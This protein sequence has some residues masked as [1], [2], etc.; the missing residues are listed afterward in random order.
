MVVDCLRC[1]DTI[2]SFGMLLQSEWLSSSYVMWLHLSQ[3]IPC[4]VHRDTQTDTGVYLFPA[5]ISDS[6]LLVSSHLLSSAVQWFVSTASQPSLCCVSCVFQRI[7]FRSKGDPNVLLSVKM[8][9][10]S[11]ILLLNF[12][13]HGTLGL[14]QVIKVGGLFG[15]DEEEEEL[16][17]K[18]AVDR[19]NTD[20]NL[21]P[22]STLVAQVERISA[23]DSFHTDK[24][25]CNLLRLGVAAIFGPLAGTTSMHVQ[26][27]CDALDLPH[28]ETRWDFQANRN[29]LSLNL[30]PR[31]AILAKAYTDL[32]KAWNWRSFAVAY[33]DNE[34]IIRVQEFFKEAQMHNWKVKL[35]QFKPGEP[36]RDTFWRIKASGEKNIVLDVKLENMHMVLKHAQQ[37]GM[38]TESHSYLI[39]S[40]DLHTINMDDYK[41]G[42]TRI[43]SYRLVDMESHELLSLIEDWARLGSRIGKTNVKPPTSIKVRRPFLSELN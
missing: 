15:A 18:F 14:P 11:V 4:L 22:R 1:T 42:K 20:P 34:G 31:P 40:L 37:V 36:Y 13:V 8:Q 7:K 21:L 10:F 43:T 30:Y 41:F 32:V 2:A 9:L 3:A 35:Y 38:M 26:S 16:V 17:F 39:T 27:I 5:I 25:T 12:L 6:L 23:G 24:K 19:I 29:D 33:E 28:I